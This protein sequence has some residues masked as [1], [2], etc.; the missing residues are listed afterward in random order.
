MSKTI[1][2]EEESQYR[3]LD[4]VEGARLYAQLRDEVKQSGLLK[5]SYGYYIILTLSTYIGFFSSLIGIYYT[6][7]P[8]WIVLLSLTFA[9]FSVQIAGLIHDAAHRSIFQSPKYNDMVGQ[10]FAT[11][12]AMG[13]NNW[14]IAHDEHHANPNQ[15]GFDPDIE[16]PFSFTPE[17]FKNSTGFTRLIGRYQAYFYYPLGS[18][19]SLTVRF[20]RMAYFEKYWGPRTYAEA[21]VFALSVLVHF[22]LP[23][24]FFGVGK[25]IAFLSI[26]TLAEGFYLFNIFAPNHKGMPELEKDVELSFIEQQVCTAR[27]VTSSP[28]IDYLYLGLNFQIEHH[29]FPGSARNN[30][31]KI[32]RFT[33]RFCKTHKI[34]YTESSALESIRII[35]GE[36]QTLSRTL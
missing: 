35:F 16:I 21:V 27:N 17:R 2:K 5:R 31:K 6:Q 8:V 36:M 20:N 14:K 22:G 7:N 19:T 9:F 12:V 30:L 3:K 1:R 11:S 32:A 10:I 18:L 34:E 24:Y 15:D 33:K 26:I 29:L 13:Y 25:A 23:F 28:V 4:L